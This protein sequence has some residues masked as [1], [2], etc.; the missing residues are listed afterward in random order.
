MRTATLALPD[1]LRDWREVLP[2]RAIQYLM[3]RHGRIIIQGVAVRSQFQ[4]MVF[5]LTPE[6]EIME[7]AQIFDERGRIL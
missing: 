6:S 2:I 1:D 4:L 3:M 7:R 5:Y